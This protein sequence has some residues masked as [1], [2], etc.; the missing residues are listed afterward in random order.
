MYS[1]KGSE[2]PESPVGRAFGFQESII[3]TIDDFFLIGGKQMQQRG[4]S[5]VLKACTVVKQKLLKMARSCRMIQ[6]SFGDFRA[7]LYQSLN[8]CGTVASQLF[9]IPNVT[10]SRFIGFGDVKKRA[11]DLKRP[12]A[13]CEM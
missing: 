2:S 13:T 11:H 7:C 4:L 5:R 1:I 10:E 3:Q 12:E 9:V 8:H 6:D